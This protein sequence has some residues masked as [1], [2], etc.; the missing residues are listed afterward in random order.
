MNL[1]LGG[2]EAMK[3][4]GGELA[5]TSKSTEANKERGSHGPN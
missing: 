3:N 5:V 4:T 1:M 2:I